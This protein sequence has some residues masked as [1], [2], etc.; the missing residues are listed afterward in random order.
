MEDMDWIDPTKASAIYTTEF[1]LNDAP[2]PKAI[3]SKAARFSIAV[4]SESEAVRWL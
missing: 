2:T 3:L 4:A 1:L